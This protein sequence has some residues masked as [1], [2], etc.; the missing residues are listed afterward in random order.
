[1]L[2]M[3]DIGIDEDFRLDPQTAK[4]GREDHNATQKTAV[5]LHNR[6]IELSKSYGHDRLEWQ[7]VSDVLKSWETGKREAFLLDH[8]SDIDR[9]SKDWSKLKARAAA[10]AATLRYRYIEQINRARTVAKLGPLPVDPDKA[11]ADAAAAADPDKAAKAA[12]A[13]AEKVAKAADKVSPELAAL[14]RAFTTEN[15]S[16]C[17]RIVEAAITAASSTRKAAA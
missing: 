2:S 16:E 11:A 8:G 5:K 7:T 9:T 15:Y 14:V 6:M 17:Q 4:L 3:K 13:A 12:A 1:M 10:C